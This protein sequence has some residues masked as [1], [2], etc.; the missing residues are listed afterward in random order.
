MPT[1]PRSR[2][3]RA[4]VLL[5]PALACTAALALLAP[6][7]AHASPTAAARATP[8]GAPDAASGPAA[9]TPATADERRVD[10][11]LDTVR[12]RPG[13]LAAFL[14]AM[15]K[16]GELHSHLSGAVST[17]LLMELAAEDGLC[18]DDA[19]STALAPPCR[20]G[21]RPATD[22][23]TD[24]AMRLRVLR[25]WSMQDFDPAA[26]GETGHDHFFATFGKFGEVAWRHPGRMLAEVL[27][28]AAEHRQFYQELMQTPAWGEDRKLADKVGWDPDLARMHQKITADGAMDALVR[29]ARDE[30]DTTTAEFRAAA[31]CDTDAPQPACAVPFRF[32][33]QVARESSPA[34]VFIQMTLAMALAERDHRFVAVNLVQPEDGEVALRDYRLHMRMLDFLHA[35]YP[36]A[37]ITLHAGELVAGLVKPE[38]LRFHIA[39]AV[40]TGHAE[41]IGHGVDIRE[42][43]GFDDV[44]RTMAERRVAV[45]VPLTS[46]HQIL[47]VQGRD[48]PFTL[49]REHGVPVVLATDDQ[50]VSRITVSDE[51][52]RA[53][54]TYG[55]TYREL[56]DLARASLEHAFLDGRS[57]WKAPGHYR[58]VADCA[59]VRPGTR[60]PPARC[61]GFLKTNAKAA[62][63][64][65][66]EAAFTRFERTVPAPR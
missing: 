60:T 14:R 31:R 50:G 37:H 61:A 56:K 49:Y 64:W 1:T 58:P 63:E 8:S 23:R 2:I 7:S 45:E 32:I 10:A 46:N 44:L 34:R 65:R 35:R 62:V 25:A 55:L 24:D 3:L 36:N 66:Q 16:G 40:R 26:A 11:Y 41:R 18:V 27:N 59:G 57:L 52:A 20:A 17:E 22:L 12:R 4:R 39:E 21:S 38:H 53:T 13:R 30:A 51:Y 54:A 48:H 15:P 5:P 6:L 28:T 9:T 43:D 33:S 19:T 29:T 42:E 47:G